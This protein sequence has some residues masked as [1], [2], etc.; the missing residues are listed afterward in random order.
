MVFNI[1]N[2]GNVCYIKSMYINEM[3]VIL[4]WLEWL[5]LR[6]CESKS[7]FLVLCW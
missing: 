6:G 5:L 7:N 1:I 2:L 4:L 3:Y